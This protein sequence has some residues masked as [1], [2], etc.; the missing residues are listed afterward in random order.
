MKE[1]KTH[2]NPSSNLK[3]FIQRFIGVISVCHVMTLS[4]NVHVEFQQ[5]EH[6]DRRVDR[7]PAIY[8]P[9]GSAPTPFL[10]QGLFKAK[11]TTQLALNARQPITFEMRGRGQATL[12]V[13]GANVASDWGT[14][15]RTLTLSQGEHALRIEYTSPAAG[16][17]QLRLFWK[18]DGFA[19]EPVPASVLKSPE[20]GLDSVLRT[21]RT[22]LANQKCA[23]C[24][25][26][27]LEINMPE[28]LEKGPSFNGIGSRLNAAWMADWIRDPQSIR[29]SAHMPR[30]FRGDDAS[31]KSA[32]IAAFLATQ[33]GRTDRLGQ[34]NAEEGGHLFQELGC[35]ACH[36][37]EEDTADRISLAGAG[38]K[39]G[40]GVLGGF[41][42]QPAQHYADTRMPT[43][44]LSRGEAENLAAFIRSLDKDTGAAT[45]LTFGDPTMGKQLVASSG[46]LNCHELDG[47]QNTFAA[48]SLAA[49]LGSKEGC[50]D[51][52]N[53]RSNAPLFHQD[54]N[55]LNQAAEP[56]TAKRLV[57]S[58]G[59]SIPQEF[60]ARQFERLRCAACHERDSVAAW[61]DQY[62]EDVAH[63]VR[64]ET[65]SANEDEALSQPPQKIPSLDHL[66]FKLQADWTASLLKGE[67]PEKT[68]PWLKA[69]MPAWPSRAENLATGFAHAAGLSDEIETREPG[70]VDH[71]AIGEKLAGIEG[72][73]CNACHAIGSQPAVAVFEGAGPN[74]KLAPGRLRSEF[75]QQWMRNPQRITPTSIMPRFTENNVSPLAQH[76]DGDADKQFEA[77]LDYLQDLAV[78]QPPGMAPGLVGEYYRVNGDWN[79]FL[80]RMNRSR[81]FFVRVD[82]RI[83]FP[84]SNDDFYGSKL[85]DSFLV[86]WT[87]TLVV[88]ESGI[89]KIHLASDDGARL[90]IGD[91][92]VMS[93]MGAH[94]FSEETEEIE[95]EAGRHDINLIFHEMGGG[96]GCVLSWTPP[97]Q[98][99]QVIPA[100]QLLHSVKAFASVQWD[101]EAWESFSEGRPAQGGNVA[102]NDEPIPSKYGSL[103]GTAVRVGMDD[104]GENVTFR[105]HVVRLDPEG[106][107]AVVFDTDTMRMAAAWLEGGLR[108][109]G[110][111]FTGGHGAFPNLRVEP[112][113]ATGATPGWADANGGFEDPRNS[114]YPA[115]GHLPKDWTH[116]KGLYRHGDNVV[117]HYTVGS[118]KVLEHPSLVQAGETK[119][120]SRRLELE[121]HSK[122]LT[123]VLADAPE[124]GERLSDTTLKVGNA[125]LRVAAKPDGARLVI[126]GGQAR[127]KLSAAARDYQVE[128]LIWRGDQHLPENVHSESIALWNL[129]NGGSVRWPEI[130][131]TQGELADESGEEPYVLDRLT[132]PYENPYGVDI[133]VG[134]F[135]FFSGGTSAALC[136]WDGDVWIVR[137]ID[138]DLDQLEWKRFA[139]GIHEPLG[140]KIVDDVIYTVSDDQITRYHDF[141]KDGEAD[142]YENFNN[143]WELTSGFHA[144]LFDLHTDPEGNFLFAFG[145]PVR[146]GGRSFERMSAHHG[147][148]LKVSKDGST[149][150][151]YASGLRAPNGIGVSPTGQVTTGDNEGTFVPR[152]PINWV[153]P[154]DFLGVIDSYEHRDQMKTTATV[155]DRRNGREEFWD[156]S[157]EPRPLAWLPKGVDNSGGGQGWVTS[158]RW[159]PFQGEMLHGS[160][161]Q[162]SLY[163]V[164][165]EKVGNQM[166]GGVVKFPLRPTSS[167]MR[168]RFNERDGQLYISGLKGWQSNAGRDGG[169]DRIRYTGNP[170]AMPSGLQATPSGLKVTFTEPLDPSTAN[171]PGSFSLRASDILWNQ[172]YGSQEYELDQRHLPPNEWKTGWTSM[173]VTGSELQPDGK[174]VLL[175]IDNWRPAHMME[176]NIDVKTTGGQNIRTRV[177][178]TVHVIP[179][180]EK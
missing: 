179:G 88:P 41:L 122:P 82:S 156:P 25:Q 106:K 111:P 92:T 172:E 150:I 96:Q 125:H 1:L 169:L 171:D 136:T 65:V 154:D 155:E 176:L 102:R 16:D 10:D 11:I 104:R 75:Y 84:N 132:L 178:H 78:K 40:L 112:L 3:R 15:S 54:L 53:A 159:G 37:M 166:Q 79:R 126:E 74:L 113:I 129:I 130:V 26:P 108:F 161:G 36:T 20:T 99:K 89:Y 44:E 109:E 68:R 47:V 168:L 52:V 45:E 34:G 100:V 97:G 164:L 120:I 39:Y 58:L 18:S 46:C 162:S 142:Y 138:D 149:L 67:T 64:T 91:D 5:G 98:T 32:H 63:L 71:I 70:S 2:S 127:L 17:A 116:Y 134:G 23:A 180:K 76:F 146:G 173:S 29:K 51:S 157:E 147:S 33:T 24:H 28:A 145:S 139:S 90:M 60:A 35:Y 87:G 56:E 110:L 83:N 133:R 160:Y 121:A 101:R 66:G 21:A 14:P 151:R 55:A 141:N 42:Q 38:R 105:S 59:H 153:E 175:H 19:F 81:P 43:F 124:G 6:M 57:A 140:L 93:F 4:A 107:A 95:L 117:F 72:F 148:V 131:T 9:A 143:D 167:V 123:L 85:R 77:L 165:K 12:F 49:V 119:A 7:H 22:E 115:L 94:S 31:Q 144:F 27:G 50:L 80:R 114:S 61:R 128:V 62:S 86:R 73:S 13:D 137:G 48:P 174:S 103:I 177:H 69:R 158:D 163:L 8:V 135:D 30:V 152:C 170:V 118:T